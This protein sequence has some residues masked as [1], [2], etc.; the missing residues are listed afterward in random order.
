MTY[1]TKITMSAPIELLSTCTKIAKA[2]DPDRGGENSFQVGDTEIYTSFWATKSF[3]NTLQYLSTHSVELYNYCVEDYN[4]R[5]TN[6][7]PP[8]L[9]ECEQFTSSISL[10]IT[11]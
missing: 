9:E 5:W 10:T 2:M 8:T 1:T 11:Q 7:I 3:S 4:R 6:L